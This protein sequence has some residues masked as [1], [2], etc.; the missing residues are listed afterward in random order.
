MPGLSSNEVKVL[1]QQDSLFVVEVK[2]PANS[3][4]LLLDCLKVKLFA[5]FYAAGVVTKSMI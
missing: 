5:L 1:H 2:S 3:S 4:E